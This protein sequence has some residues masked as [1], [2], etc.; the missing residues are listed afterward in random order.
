MDAHETGL[1]AYLEQESDAQE[2]AP[3]DEPRIG[4]G[5]FPEPFDGCGD[6]GGLFSP[7]RPHGRAALLRPVYHRAGRSPQPDINPAMRRA[8]LS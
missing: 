7:R 5:E 4:V 6:H 3:V 8:G 1:P 2:A